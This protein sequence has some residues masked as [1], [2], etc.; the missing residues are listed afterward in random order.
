MATKD[1][2]TVNRRWHDSGSKVSMKAWAR[3]VYARVDHD[4]ETLDAIK[5]WFEHKGARI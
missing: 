5:R 4:A 1:N 3:D 2:K